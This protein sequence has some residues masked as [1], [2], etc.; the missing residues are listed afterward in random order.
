MPQPML[1]GAVATW[2]ASCPPGPATENTKHPTDVPTENVVQTVLLSSQT[3]Q[4]FLE[5]ILPGLNIGGMSDRDIPSTCL[6]ERVF[7]CLLILLIMVRGSKL[8]FTRL[9]PISSLLV[10]VSPSDLAA[11]SS[12]LSVCLQSGATELQD[13]P[14]VPVLMA[15]SSIRATVRLPL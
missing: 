1:I 2:Q 11:R 8:L 14:A 9:L 15:C 10:S 4:T 13:P 12:S 7:A 5:L 3:L 6:L